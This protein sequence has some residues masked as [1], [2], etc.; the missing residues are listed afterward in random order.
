M[1]VTSN[2]QSYGQR[3]TWWSLVISNLTVEVHMVVTSNKQSYGQRFTWWSLVI[4]NLTV[5]GS[6]GGH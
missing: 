1:V 3:F 6:H 4:S 5:R 2:K